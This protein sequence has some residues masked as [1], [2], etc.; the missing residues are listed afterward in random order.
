MHFTVTA[1]FK[2]HPAST[3]EEYHARLG[4]QCIRRATRPFLAFAKIE[5]D[6]L[7]GVRVNFTKSGIV[8]GK[9]CSIEVIKVG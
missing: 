4:Y 1:Q 3:K 2:A 5:L 9:T 6:A 7:Q 8:Q